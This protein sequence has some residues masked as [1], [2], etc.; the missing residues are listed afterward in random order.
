LFGVKVPVSGP[1]GAGTGG[2]S[3]EAMTLVEGAATVGEYVGVSKD[4]MNGTRKNATDVVADVEIPF[5]H[6]A[7]PLSARKDM[8][9]A[10]KSS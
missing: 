3:V 9:W 5:D 8:H 10:L 6:T 7:Q 2:G 4:S 1:V